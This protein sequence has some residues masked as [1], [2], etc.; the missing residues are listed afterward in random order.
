MGVK[1]RRGCKAGDHSEIKK[2]QKRTNHREETM[3]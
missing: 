2:V 1:M 3:A